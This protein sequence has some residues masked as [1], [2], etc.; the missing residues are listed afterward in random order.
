MTFGPPT[1]RKPPSPT[2]EQWRPVPDKPHLEQNN[3]NPPKLRTRMPLP[4][5]KS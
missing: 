2:T 5:A 4:P 1:N 3:D